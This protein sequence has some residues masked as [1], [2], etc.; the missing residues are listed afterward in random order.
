VQDFDPDVQKAVNRIQPEAQT[1]GVIEA[2]REAKFR[3]V[4][5]DL[6]YGLPKQNVITMGQTIAKVIKASPDR[7]SLYNYAHLPHLFKMQK[8]ILD[9]DLPSGETKLDMLSLSIKRLT[10]AGY[11]YIGMDHFAKPDDDLAVAQKQGRL[12]RNFQG[13]STHADTDLV[14][15]GISAISSVAMTYSQ[16]VKTL[17]AYYA[18][19]DKNELPIARGIKLGMDDALRRLIIQMLMC[20]FELSISS[21]EQAYPITFPNY[22]ATELEKLK[23]LAIDGLLTMD[24]DWI[25]V[26]MKGRLLIRNICMV[27]DRYLNEQQDRPRY[28]KTI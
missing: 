14:A 11:V 18:H 25:S 9:E 15:C 3:S 19:L 23:G 6:I 8:N 26:T 7:I 16:N 10:D 21:I 4:S 28:S 24:D 1:I 13:Y 27:F 22:F 20:N 17:D 12:H 5:I 2:A